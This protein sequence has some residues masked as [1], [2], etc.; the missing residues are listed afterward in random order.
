MDP[1]AKGVVVTKVANGS[2]A[3]N[4]GFQPGDIVRSVNGGA[5][6]STGELKSR[7]A[8][9]DGWLI[10]VDRGG[11]RMTLRVGR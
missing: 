7:L 10:V 3:A 1:M 8:A 11:Q 2:I 5:I 9:A 4:Y 6:S